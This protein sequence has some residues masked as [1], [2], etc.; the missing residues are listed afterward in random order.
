[1]ATRQERIDAFTHQGFQR[2]SRLSFFARITSAP[3][4]YRFYVSGVAVLGTVWIPAAESKRL[5][6][7]GACGCDLP[8]PFSGESIPADRK[9]RVK[10]KW[11]QRNE[12]TEHVQY[13]HVRVRTMPGQ[14]LEE[15]NS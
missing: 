6:S 1:M 5:S 8:A 10:L 9:A 14:M 11:G 7:V 15:V 4:S 3:M 13:L 2:T 12:A